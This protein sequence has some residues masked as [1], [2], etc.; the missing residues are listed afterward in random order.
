[1]QTLTNLAPTALD[2]RLAQALTLS[3]VA[4]IG[5][6]DPASATVH[7]AESRR[8]ALELGDSTAVVAA[9]W[10]QALAAHARGQLRES[11]RIDL[12]ETSSMPDLAV[13]VFDGQLCVTQR[14]LYGAAPYDEVIGFAE[15]LLEEAERLGAARGR[16]FAYTLRGE[17]RLLSG[18]L[19]SAKSDLRLARDLHRAMAAPTGEAHALQRLAEAAWY[20]GDAGAARRLGAEALEVARESSVGFHLF[21]RIYGTAVTAAVDSDAAVTVVDEAELAIRGPSDTCPGCRITFVVPAAI[22]A[23]RVGDLER[24]AG[25]LSTAESLAE[26][27]MKLPAWD[28]AV[29]EARAEVALARGE[30]AA[31]SRLFAAAGERFAAAGHPLDAHRCAPDRLGSPA[32]R[33]RAQQP[34]A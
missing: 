34:S 27:V 25:Y 5:R 28:A 32:A 2:G 33:T 24:A 11:L 30:R 12:L 23:A 4:A 18:E 22:A 10:A 6:T 20:G 17:A 7:A 26:V 29:D 8:L 15:S 19:E 16:A 14:L 21:D 9:S 1:M 3:A 13:A 31:A